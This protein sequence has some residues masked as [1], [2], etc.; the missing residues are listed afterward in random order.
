M[1][2]HDWTRVAP[3][4]FHHFHHDWISAISRSLNDG[5]LPKDYYALAEQIAGGLGPN[6][7]TLGSLRQRESDATGNG[8][9][10]GQL[11]GSGGVAVAAAPPRVRWTAKTDSERYAANRKRISI[12][13]V[14]GDEV[15]AV[16]EIIS[17]G[18][19]DSR[20]GLRSFVEKALELLDANVHLLV[21]DLFP[22]GP[23]DPQGIHG[24][25]WSELA[26]DV[27]ELP[28]DKPLTLAAY[29]AGLE[30]TAFV[31]PVAVDDGL[32]DMP[33]F[34]TPGL[35]VPVPLEA[36]YLAAFDGVPERWRRELAAAV[37]QTS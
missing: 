4:I 35:Y 31:E 27:F 3:G 17:P 11:P 18:N 23:L 29:S 22:P 9:G 5:R 32:P 2:I 25:I 28:P 15:V 21:L 8:N 12:R 13:H 24:A 14:S 36:T 1:P 19:K 34:L 33:L 37:R 6:V 20:H 26:S 7:L 16:L 30:T 10:A